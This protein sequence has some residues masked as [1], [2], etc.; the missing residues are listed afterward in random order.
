[1]KLLQ[2]MASEFS[3][4]L[5][6]GL[7]ITDGFIVYIGDVAHMESC[8]ATCFKN[9]AKDIMHDKSPEI[10]DVCGAV[11]SGAAA[12][13]TKGLTVDGGE[14]SFAAGEGVE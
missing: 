1:M 2:P 3:K 8:H 14:R 6:G 10:T 5:A 13:K 9:A 11:N 7:G 12:V 4:G